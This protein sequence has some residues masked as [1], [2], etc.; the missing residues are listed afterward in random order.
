MEENSSLYL[1]LN[2]GNYKNWF[3]ARH[4]VPENAMAGQTQAF[5]TALESDVVL[6]IRANTKLQ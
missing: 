5:Y 2:N 3:H 4:A 1:D 6:Q